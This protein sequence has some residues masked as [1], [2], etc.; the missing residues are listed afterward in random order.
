MHV[1]PREHLLDLG[2][3]T[4][5]HVRGP[6]NWIDAAAR[7][8]GWSEALRAAEVPRPRPLVG[9]WSAAGGAAAGT[10]LALDP[11]VTA[12][13]AAN[14]Q[15]ALGVV[16]ALLDV[17]R[18]VP[19]DVSVVGFD[20]TPESAYFAP[21][22]TTIRQ[23]FGELG[24][25][26]VALLREHHGRQRAGRARHGARPSDRAQKYVRTAGSRTRSSLGP[27]RP[28]TAL[29]GAVLPCFTLANGQGLYSTDIHVQRAFRR[30]ISP[31]CSA[32]AFGV[33]AKSVRSTAINPNLGT[34]PRVHSKLSRSDQCR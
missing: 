17:G 24:R 23:D 9:D 10:R 28:E 12:V 27:V 29:I 4:V 34:Y 18:R 33:R 22:L 6:R 2:H 13:F 8:R 20:D 16:R 11:E 1:V 31:R 25:R 7:T 5:H 30:A 21:P 26:C 3:R 14:D 32:L 19:E 15:T